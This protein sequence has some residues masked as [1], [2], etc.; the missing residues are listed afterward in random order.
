ML[1]TTST[2]KEH[3][4]FALP[5][6]FTR[7]PKEYGENGESEPVGTTDFDY[8]PESLEGEVREA[9]DRGEKIEPIIKRHVEAREF[10]LRADGA[11]TL[12]SEI[13]TA[14]NAGLAA[15][16]ISFACGIAES[17]GWTAREMWQR[18]HITK[19]AFDQGVKSFRQ[20]LGIPI[21][22]VNQRDEKAR[23]KMRMRN[24]RA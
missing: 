20:R 23:D 14:A 8:G 9:L 12:L 6:G 17:E 22:T 10:E 11:K 4:G 5:D 19:Q 15:C 2:N 1:P 7:A 18:Y 24:F 21:R 13:I 16:Q 3:Q